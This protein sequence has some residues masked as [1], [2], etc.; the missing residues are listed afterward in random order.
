[1]VEDGK[2]YRI[3]ADFDHISGN[4]M[5]IVVGGTTTS[6]SG[7]D[8]GKLDYLEVAGSGGIFQIKRNS[9]AVEFYLDNITVTEV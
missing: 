2:T 5:R 8:T 7:S 4:N 3:R 1:M 9:G 6:F